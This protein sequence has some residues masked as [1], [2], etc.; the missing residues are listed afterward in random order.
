MA[1]Q[2]VEVAALS[3]A[4]AIPTSRL[5]EILERPGTARLAEIVTIAVYFGSSI[6]S[7]FG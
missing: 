5:Q 7:F 3:E 4:T 2:G 1:E 6:N